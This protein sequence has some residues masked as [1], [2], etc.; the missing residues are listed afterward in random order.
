MWAVLRLAV[1]GAL[2]ERDRAVW[3][4]TAKYFYLKGYAAG[5]K[6]RPRTQVAA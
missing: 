1:D 4:A 3:A 2:T 5:R 6:F